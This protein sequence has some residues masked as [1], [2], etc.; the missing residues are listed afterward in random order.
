[1]IIRRLLWKLQI[2]AIQLIV[3]VTDLICY[4]IFVVQDTC[5]IP[6]N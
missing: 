4:V 2:T 3:L 1:L 5:H 6:Y